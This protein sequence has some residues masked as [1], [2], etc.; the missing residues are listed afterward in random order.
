MGLEANGL[1]VKGSYAATDDVTMPAGLTTVAAITTA[2]RAATGGSADELAWF[3]MGSA[4]AGK[5][6]PILNFTVVGT[7]AA[8]QT[9]TAS[10]WAVHGKPD[11]NIYDTTAECIVTLFGTVVFTLGTATGIS[12]SSFVNNSYL[13]ADTV[14]Y[15]AA[16]FGTAVAD[17]FGSEPAASSDAANRAGWMLLPDSGNV[18]A[19]L[20]TLKNQAG[21]KVSKI[22]GETGT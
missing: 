19:F 10:I 11:F 20:V 13:F 6:Q 3:A 18:A 7:D 14:V 5:R 21:S 1:E 16:T 15:T 17:A 4:R 22:V 8:N 2:V 12:G 9:V